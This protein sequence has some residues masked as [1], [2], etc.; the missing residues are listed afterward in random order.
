MKKIMIAAL[1][2]VTVLAFSVPAMAAAIDDASGNVTLGGNAIYD[3][4][5][6]VYLDYNMDNDANPQYYSLGTVHSGGNR[7]F[8]T[9]SETSVIWWK[10]C[11]KG[12]SDSPVV[13]VTWTTGDFEGDGSWTSL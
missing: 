2:L 5:N 9:T 8:V 4:S 13:T 10:T 1:A 12:T 6:A 7:M 11:D 3:L